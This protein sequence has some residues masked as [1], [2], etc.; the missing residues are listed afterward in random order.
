MHKTY[1]YKI[2]NYGCSKN[3]LQEYNVAPR[4]KPT[5]TKYKAK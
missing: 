5:R 3:K 4:T 1:T 2:Y